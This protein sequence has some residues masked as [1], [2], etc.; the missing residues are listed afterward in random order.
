MANNARLEVWN[1]NSRYISKQRERE[2]R[3]MLKR[4]KAKELKRLMASK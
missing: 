1:Y 3:R 2:M 4:E